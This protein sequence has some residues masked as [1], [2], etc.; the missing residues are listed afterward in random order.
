[1][2]WHACLVL[3][4]EHYPLL[5]SLTTTRYRSHQLPKA[6]RL[7]FPPKVILT[8]INILF[9]ELVGVMSTFNPVKSVKVVE[10]E[11]VSLFL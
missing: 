3:F 2:K 6:Y 9:E 8:R 5:Y 10:V 11:K 1:M 7:V 4:P